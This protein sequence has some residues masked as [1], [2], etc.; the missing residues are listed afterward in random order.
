MTIDTDAGGE[1]RLRPW[2]GLVRRVYG[3]PRPGAL[4]EAL[5]AFGSWAAG[6]RVPWLAGIWALALVVLLVFG[7]VPTVGGAATAT[8]LLTVLFGLRLLVTDLGQPS[9]GHAAFLAVGA[10][11][12]AFLRLRLG[13]DG[14][15][16]ALLAALVAGGAGWAVGWGTSRLRPSFLALATWAF[17]WLVF[18]AIGAFPAV[19]GGVGGIT[20][21]S[22]MAIRMAPLG[23]QARFNEAGHLLL[24]SFILALVLLFLRSAQQSTLGRSWAALRDGPGLVRAL[25]FDVAAMRRWGFVVAAALAGL[26]GSLMAQMVGVVDPTRYSPLAS[27]SLFVAVLIAAPMGFLGPI[28]G[29]LVILGLPALFS[30]AAIALHVPT[31]PAQGV[32]VAALTIVALVLSQTLRRREKAAAPDASTSRDSP[33]A[34]R[35]SRSRRAEPPPPSDE[36]PILVLRDLNHHFDGVD[37]LVDITMEFQPGRVH[38]IIGPNGSGK[39]TLLKCVS[40]AIQADRG[41][42]ILDGEPLSPL[43][44]VQRAQIGVTRTFQRTV[45]LPE[46]TPAD[47]VELGLQQRSRASSWLQAVL[48]T[49]AYRAEAAARQRTAQWMLDLFGL[50]TLANDQP[51]TLSSGRQR[52][53]QMAAAAATG[54]SLLLLDEPSAGMLGDEIDLLV[55]AIGTLAGMG[56][57][58]LLVEHNISFLGRVADR[59]TVLHEGRVLAEGS[60]KEIAANPDVQRV[61]LGPELAKPRWRHMFL[62]PARAVEVTMARPTE[63]AEGAGRRRRPGRR[64]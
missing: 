36:P 39:S 44:E 62:G 52:L 51:E 37:A 53:L 21:G 17:G 38:G 59:V 56:L 31:S 8:Y 46:L 54:P 3:P 25:G 13:L 64:S 27:L 40:G 43:S 23:L 34:P 55:A 45:L 9:L 61:Y 47:H 14:L 4:P 28:A 1:P 22:S 32:L 30:A 58:V 35:R 16:S 63:R 33:P 49:P 50:G 18:V 10:Y 42:I 41:E 48:K 24:A 57:T 6:E 7:D 11:L 15:I 20:L 26:C 60:P 2:G 29:L 5:R 19:S 12:T